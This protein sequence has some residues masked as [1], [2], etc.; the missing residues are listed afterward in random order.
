MES[1][2]NYNLFHKFIETYSP[3]GFIGINPD[4]SLMAELEKRMETSNQF[5]LVGDVI[6]LKILF[7]SKRS[8]KM[9]GVEPENIT[10]YHFF[11]A[12]HP[13]DI[14]RHGLARTQLFKMAQEL[15]IAQNGC[16]LLT[17]NL[18]IKGINEKYVCLLFQCY[19]F[20]SK[21][22]TK[23]VYLLQVHTNVDWCKKVKKENHYYAGNDL[24]YFQYPDEKLLQMGNVF[25]KREF[26]IIKL[27]EL[28]LSSEE[29][30]QKLFLSLYTINA[31]RANILKKSG[32]T[33]LSE[34]VYDLMEQG[35]I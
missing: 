8:S 29:I 15:F 23:T 35:R 34:L 22:P 11:E 18:K 6:Q 1:H 16:S 4:D 33:R 19:L 26:E 9:I 24:S 25:T 7:A 28:G 30:A 20:Y 2:H 21:N 27:I 3:T 12:T 13:D 14:Q 31:H 32:K 5:F 17:T 10:P